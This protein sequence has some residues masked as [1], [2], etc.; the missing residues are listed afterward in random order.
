MSDHDELRRVALATSSVELPSGT[1]LVLLDEIRTLRRIGRALLD[2]DERGQGVGWSE[3]M[4]ALHKL[5][6]G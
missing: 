3:T 2:Y 6:R 4:D 1:L 5:I